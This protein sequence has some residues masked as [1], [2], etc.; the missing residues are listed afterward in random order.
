LSDAEASQFAVDTA[1]AEVGTRVCVLE[2]NLRHLPERRVVE[3]KN[4]DNPQLEEKLKSKLLDLEL[5]RTSLITKFQPSYR[6]VQEVDEE[7]SQA[8]A[9]IQSEEVKPLRDETTQDDPEFQWAHSEHLKNEIELQALEQKR[10]V[11]REQVS[12]YRV[13]AEKL[14]E[15]AV[16]QHDLEQQVK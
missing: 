6:L 8:K 14:E 16:A 15:S 10:A 7:I 9:A 12:A 2:S 5:Q 13:T 3:N 11:A 4:A 1:V